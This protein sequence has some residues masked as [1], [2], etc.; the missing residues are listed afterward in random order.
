MNINPLYITGLFSSL[1]LLICGLAVVYYIR[2]TPP[3]LSPEEQEELDR[4]RA[5][6]IEESDLLT[7]IWKEAR[8]LSSEIPQQL[9]IQNEMAFRYNEEQTGKKRR[10]RTLVKFPVGLLTTTEIWFAFD[11]RHLPYGTS[12]YDIKNPNNHVVENLQYAIHRPVSLYEDEEYNLFLRVGLKNAIMGIPKTVKWSDVHDQLPASRPLAVALGITNNSRLVYQDIRTWPHIFV[13]GSTGMGKST[14]LKAWICSLALKN[15]P[16]DLRFFFIDLKNGLELGDF[17]KLPHCAGFAKEPP[18]AAKLIDEAVA[19]G[20]ERL[21]RFEGKCKDL[22]GWN[23]Q[24]SLDRQPYIIVVIDELFDLMAD[25]TLRGNMIDQIGVINRKLRAAGV[26]NVLCTQIVNKQVAD[27]QIIGN[28]PARCVFSLPGLSHSMLALNNGRATT[29][30]DHRGRAIYRGAGGDVVIQAPWITEREVQRSIADVLEN[31]QRGRDFT[32]DDLWKIIRYNL[33]GLAGRRELLQAV[34]GQIGS[35]RL[36]KWLQGADYR[37][38][39]PEGSVINIDGDRYI[40]GS[41]KI[42]GSRQ[43]A[44]RLIPING[45]LPAT[46]DEL[47]QMYLAVTGDGP[48]PGTDNDETEILDEIDETP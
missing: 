48:E 34:D 29:L 38:D 15:T 18:E 36:Q 8:F 6:A 45:Y 25:R 5:R 13:A 3:E 42:A 24:F 2:R 37:F 16:D 23:S 22:H 47:A 46:P 17:A 9:A 32:P 43:Q 35:H 28:A 10:K 19:L 1:A 40:L 39:D 14:Q 27:I 12:F 31:H 44:R 11:G 26:H 30:N 21:T 41:I 7:A 4:E 33:G 20:L